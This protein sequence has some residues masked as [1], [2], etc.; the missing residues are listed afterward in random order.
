MDHIF[1]KGKTKK[2][3]IFTLG[4]NTFG[5]PVEQASQ[6][7]KYD[8]VYKVPGTP[9]YVLGAL[10]I[11][12]RI[13]SLVHLKHRLGLGDELPEKGTGHV[14]FVETS[15]TIGMLV[16]RVRTLMDIPLSSI[17][18]DIELV[19]TRIDMD[20]LK[21]AATIKNNDGTLEI[22]VLLNLDMILSEY[23]VEEISQH[24][25]QLEEALKTKEK[26]TLE[27]E[28]L[29]ILDLADDFSKSNEDSDF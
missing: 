14:I 28:Q 29:E 8:K 13:I 12:G 23:E 7:I 19:S 10:N 5:V 4:E 15:E 9:D 26:I 6:V 22:I 21:G 2:Y 16:D 3:V 1:D 17:K 24:R 27:D 11:R 20:F 25:A 18:E